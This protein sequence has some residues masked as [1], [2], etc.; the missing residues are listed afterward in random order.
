M[1][2]RTGRNSLRTA[3][4]TC[5]IR[6]VD[7]RTQGCA[8]HALLDARAPRLH[9]LCED[10][11]HFPLLHRTAVTWH[12]SHGK[13]DAGL[14]AICV[15]ATRL[16]A[17]GTLCGT[18][19]FWFADLKASVPR[20]EHRFER[21]HAVRPAAG[22]RDDFAGYGSD[23]RARA[24]CGTRLHCLHREAVQAQRPRRHLPL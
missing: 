10:W 22:A 3:S 16:L 9:E 18:E 13:T 24:E 1:A 4:S 6:G 21:R 20:I 5:G 23:F 11:S 14:T 7:F 8:E 12:R 17:S 15:T 2:Q 19:D